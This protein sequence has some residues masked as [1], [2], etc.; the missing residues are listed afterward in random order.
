MNVLISV[1]LCSYIKDL[2]ALGTGF[3][4]VSLIYFGFLCHKLRHLRYKVQNA[5]WSGQVVFEFPFLV[6]KIKIKLHNYFTP[7]ILYKYNTTGLEEA[8]SVAL[9]QAYSFLSDHNIN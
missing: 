2:F 8:L 4:N 6:E 1:T 9:L 3:L 7:S 5:N